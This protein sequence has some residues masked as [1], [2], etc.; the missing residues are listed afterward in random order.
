M[1]KLTMPV[2]LIILVFWLPLRGVKVETA[3]VPLVEIPLTSP[4]TQDQETTHILEAEKNNAECKKVSKFIIAFLNKKK[5]NQ[6]QR[7]VHHY[8]TLLT[9]A[10]LSNK[11]KRDF[12]NLVLKA[13]NKKKI[14][15]QDLKQAI[16]NITLDLEQLLYQEEIIWENYKKSLCAIFCCPCTVFQTSKW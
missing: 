13:A 2:I 4:T 5:I 14:I 10:Y 11:E 12:Y 7:T 3:H 1:K 16:D 15:E 6:N 9:S 8:E